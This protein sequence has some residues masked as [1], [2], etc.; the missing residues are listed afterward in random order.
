MD[1]ETEFMKKGDLINKD[2]DT[3]EELILA[4]KDFFGFADANDDEKKTWPYK[5]GLSVSLKNVV[6]K[7]LFVGGMSVGVVGD[8]FFGKSAR[9]HESLRIKTDKGEYSPTGAQMKIYNSFTNEYVLI[10][11]HP[12]RK[13]VKF[14][15]YGHILSE[16]DYKSLYYRTREYREE[17]EKTLNENLGTSGLKAPIQ[18][19]KIKKKISDTIDER[20]G[21]NWFLNRGNHY[22]AVTNVMIDKFGV[23]NLFLSDEWQK[24]IHKLYG[25]GISQLENEITSYLVEEFGEKD[26]FCF[27]KNKEQM[28]ILDFLKKKTYRLDYANIKYKI[29]IEIHGDYWHCNPLLYKKNYFHPQ[30]EKIATEIWKQD[31]LRFNSVKKLSGMKGMVIWENDWKKNNKE[32]KDKIKKFFNEN[33]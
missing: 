28:H 13:G 24:E 11:L 12:S 10:D 29:F 3:Q 20:Y 33:S 16:K 5:N 21:V 32:I 22:S 1:Y 2:F 31:K 8:C 19:E 15:T 7:E 27:V 9:G 17:Y 26:S 25:N 14:W 18:S 6:G 30:K 23:D 4:L